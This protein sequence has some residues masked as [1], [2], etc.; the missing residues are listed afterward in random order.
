[1]TNPLSDPNHFSHTR[2]AQT[3]AEV[4][5]VDGWM[6]VPVQEFE[7]IIWLREHAPDLADEVASDYRAPDAIG[8]YERGRAA[9]I[10]IGR[11][12]ANPAFSM[13]FVEIVR[14]AR[15]GAGAR[16]YADWQAQALAKVKKGLLPIDEWI[17]WGK[18]RKELQRAI[19]KVAGARAALCLRP[20]GMGASIHEIPLRGE[21]SAELN[22]IVESLDHG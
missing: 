16:M 21:F 17:A 8:A 13:E 7:A 1:M 18:A 4:D 12:V 11:A 15:P 14:A 9:A 2:G 5:E 19:S 20:G 22:Q 10:R 3:A 6:F